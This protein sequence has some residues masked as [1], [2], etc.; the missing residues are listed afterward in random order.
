MFQ[1]IPTRAAVEGRFNCL[2]L[3][4]ERDILTEDYAEAIIELSIARLR[5]KMQEELESVRKHYARLSREK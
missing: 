3:I 4:P 5:V 1:Q 2:L